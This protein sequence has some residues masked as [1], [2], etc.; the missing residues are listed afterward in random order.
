MDTKK[1][2]QSK[3]IWGAII[4]L[5]AL[6]LGYFGVDVGPDEQATFVDMVVGAINEIMALVGFVL[7]T[8]GRV[9]ADKAIK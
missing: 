7:A 6:V 3:T 8:I 9:K 1:W 4:M 5:A 2:W